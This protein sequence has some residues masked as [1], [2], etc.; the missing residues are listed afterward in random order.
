MTRMNN[1]VIYLLL[2]FSTLISSTHMF[3][4][5]EDKEEEPISD[6]SFPSLFSS[7]NNDGSCSVGT[8]V[9]LRRILK[10]LFNHVNILQPNELDDEFIYQSSITYDDYLV[11]SK[12]LSDDKLDCANL[13]K[14]DTLLSNFISNAQVLRPNQI[15][16]IRNPLEY[17]GSLPELLVNPNS[18]FRTVQYWHD[19][20]LIV[21]LTCVGLTSWFLRHRVGYSKKMAC[22]LAFMIT[23][24][25][26][27][28]MHKRSSSILKQ[29]ER[30][31]RCANPSYITR[32]F[33][34]LN[35]DY[36]NCRAIYG[37]HVPLVESSNVASILIQFLSE[38]FFDPLVTFGRKGG[39][40]IQQY[41]DAF[42]FWQQIS[43]APMFII[44]GIMSSASVVL[45]FSKSLL[46]HIFTRKRSR[47]PS[48]QN[49]LS[50][51]TPKRKQHQN[52][53]HQ[54]KQNSSVKKIK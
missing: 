30:I 4:P 41:L 52:N 36:D 51:C 28:Y 13:H 24:F 21:I 39:Q 49:R 5:F 26:E 2:Y 50:L 1:I 9:V 22:L 6:T 10:K 29:Q 19:G 3:D 32:I 54:I 46:G 44:I 33:A 38:L 48:N 15:N 40:A 42:P 14:L 37:S 47:S 12:Y 11:M 25:V 8:G 53:H 17:I 18:L 7:G 43:L 45:Y 27:F 35:Y 31:E 23:G 20:Y 34:S 16:M